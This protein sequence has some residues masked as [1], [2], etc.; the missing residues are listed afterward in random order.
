MS[1][2]INLIYGD[3][4]TELKNIQSDSI[5]LTVTSPPYDNLRSYDGLS[6]DKFKLICDELYRVTKDG[7]VIIWVVNDAVI[8]GS[9]SCT[10][11]KQALY[12]REV[13]FNLHDTMIYRKV[14][15][16]PL[17]H[18]R[19]E[20][21]FEY[22]FCFS[23]GRPKTF[24]PIK[25]PC[26]TYGKSYTYGNNRRS[27][28]DANQA[29]RVRDEVIPCHEMKI[30]DNI[31]EYGVGLNKT[32]HPA[33]FPYMLPYEQIVSWSNVGDTVLDPFMGGGTTGVAA[34]DLNR[35]FIGIEINEKYFEISK[36]NIEY[37][38]N[39]KRED[40][41]KGNTYREESLF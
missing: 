25:I 40:K 33:T 37:G 29:I 10:S 16:M 5:D 18:N 20:Q 38:I 24:N 22:M 2:N 17:N 30:K 6:F 15:Y 28:L 12:F 34:K 1:I 36:N 32:G 31:F 26:K 7:G 3:S 41:K 35:N 9:E 21:C 19:Y 8:D 4:Q 23:K 11:F 27:E 13:G 14:N 39:Y